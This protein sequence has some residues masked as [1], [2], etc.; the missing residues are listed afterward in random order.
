MP[1]EVLVHEKVVAL[2]V[3]H[4]QAD[5]F[6][7]IERRDARE[8]ELLLLVQPHELLIQ[9]QRR[10]T[11]RHAEH[12]VRLGVEQ[13]GDDV[14]RRLA[15]LLVVSLNDDFH[16]GA[17][18]LPAVWRVVYAGI[19]AVSASGGEGCDEDG[20][21]FVS[22]PV[23]GC[24]L[25]T[26]HMPDHRHARYANRSEDLDATEVVLIHIDLNN[27]VRSPHTQ[28]I[29]PQCLDRIVY[30]V[31][32]TLVEFLRGE[33]VVI[34]RPRGAWMCATTAG[35]ARDED[36]HPGD[37]QTRACHVSPVYRHG[38]TAARAPT[39]RAAPWA[40]GCCSAAGNSTPGCSDRPNRPP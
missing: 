15:H 28:P 11:R 29:G 27:A 24:R 31:E 34:E 22:T 2:G 1:E 7:E 23:T 9:A 35:R 33:G 40:A 5:V 32:G 39:C 14:R 36:R 25:D 6:V 26:I 37:R 16:Q 13:L 3:I 17:A 10:G 20:P 30:G 38:A 21:R 8:V 4:G 12:G 18:K 19:Q